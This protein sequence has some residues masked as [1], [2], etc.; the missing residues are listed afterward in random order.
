MSVK[1]FLAI[2]AAIGV[3]YGIAFLLAPGATLAVYGNAAPSAVAILLAR[4]FGVALLSLGLAVWFVK[5]TS[6]W[7]ALRG[8]LLYQLPLFR[9]GAPI[10]ADRWT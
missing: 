1:L 5:E 8:L 2:A 6:D 3:L 7:T 10:R 4:Y 9:T